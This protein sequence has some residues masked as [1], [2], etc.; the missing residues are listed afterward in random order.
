MSVLDIKV[1]SVRKVKRQHWN[2]AICFNTS[3]HVWFYYQAFLD[4]SAFTHPVSLYTSCQPLPT[5]L[6]LHILSVSACTHPVSLCTSFQPL[7][8]L[9]VF[10]SKSWQSSLLFISLLR[11][12]SASIQTTSCQSSHPI[13]A[14]FMCQAF[15][16][17]HYS[18]SAFK[19]N[20][21]SIHTKSCH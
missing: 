19:P 15:P 8:V 18:L 12:L 2:P 10:Y 5:C 16:S 7:R 1:Q 20:H 21:A 9:P 3:H 14:A 13:L 6:P 4:W 17:S 11:P